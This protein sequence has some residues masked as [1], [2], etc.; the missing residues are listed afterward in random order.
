[1]YLS[2]NHEMLTFQSQLHLLF[3]LS[4]FFAISSSNPNNHTMNSLVMKKIFSPLDHLIEYI[5]NNSEVYNCDFNHLQ[6][7]LF[8]HS[9]DWSFQLSVTEFAV[10]MKA[11]AEAAAKNVQNFELSKTGN[12]KNESDVEIN[13]IEIPSTSYVQFPPVIIPKINYF[14]CSTN[15]NQNSYMKLNIHWPKYFITQKLVAPEDVTSTSLSSDSISTVSLLLSSSERSTTRTTSKYQ[16]KKQQSTNRLFQEGENVDQLSLYTFYESIPVGC[17]QLKIQFLSSTLESK[18]V[19]S[20]GSNKQ[21]IRSLFNIDNNSGYE[22]NPNYDIDQN[23]DLDESSS[24]VVY[25]S[26]ISRTL[27]R[28]DWSIFREQMPDLENNSL[29]YNVWINATLPIYAT[30]KYNESSKYKQYINSSEKFTRFTENFIDQSDE[31]IAVDTNQSLFLITTNNVCIDDIYLF[32]SKD[33][34]LLKSTCQRKLTWISEK[35]NNSVQIIRLNSFGYPILNMTSVRRRSNVTSNIIIQSFKSMTSNRYS[36]YNGFHIL[37]IAGSLILALFITF[38]A[39]LFIITFSLSIMCSQRKVLLNSSVAT[40]N[41]ISSRNK[42]SQNLHPFIK[43]KKKQLQHEHRNNHRQVYLNCHHYQDKSKDDF[44]KILPED[45]INSLLNGLPNHLSS[46]S[47]HGLLYNQ[48]GSQ[49]QQQ[50]NSQQAVTAHQQS[51]IDDNSTELSLY[52]QDDQNELANTIN[53]LNVD[54]ADA[55]ATSAIQL[56]RNWKFYKQRGTS[57]CC[58]SPTPSGIGVNTVVNHSGI[59]KPNNS[60]ASMLLYMERRPLFNGDCIVTADAVINDDLE[61]NVMYRCQSRVGSPCPTS[62]PEVRQS[63]ILSVNADNELII[64][65]SYAAVNEKN[66]NSTCHDRKEDRRN[67]LLPNNTTDNN[68]H[69]M[70]TV[71]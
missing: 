67:R 16:I 68:N 12:N 51:F 24:S 58:Y 46:S 69:E 22:Y 21:T 64:L 59:M 19:F 13:Q 43:H 26:S 70:S 56:L 29:P 25:T 52:M 65:P 60:N 28:L 36:L 37:W 27:S 41:D 17:L 45:P 48:S 14:P 35:M 34:D 6:F 30:N 47:L 61:E 32:T 40:M 9:S 23:E 39:I 5:H 49:K 3:L 10:Q 42:N 55:S 11:A 57:S 63:L 1:M 44:A 66:I 62:V 8:E 31:W 7:C 54:G 2:S 50:R 53:G 33:R 4:T 20:L 38:L 15:Q 18:I 71:Y